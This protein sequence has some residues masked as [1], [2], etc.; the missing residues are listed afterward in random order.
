MLTPI[1]NNV[2]SMKTS[3]DIRSEAAARVKKYRH[4]NRLKN[5]ILDK[6]MTTEQQTLTSYSVL[7]DPELNTIKT[8][9]GISI[10]S[11]DTKISCF[12][13]VMRK[14]CSILFQTNLIYV[15]E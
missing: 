5:V 9:A 6:K 13:E 12:N 7:V 11:A 2:F 8:L 3:R 1:K 14:K 15:E 4:M 10:N